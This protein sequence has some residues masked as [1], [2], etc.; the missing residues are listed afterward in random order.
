MDKNIRDSQID[1]E[2]GSGDDDVENM[3]QP[4]DMEYADIDAPIENRL[5]TMQE[6][7]ET[8]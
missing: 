3:F 2:V 8:K 5:K 7:R 1:K 4:A 6:E